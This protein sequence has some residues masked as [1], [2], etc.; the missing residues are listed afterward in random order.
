MATLVR[1]GFALNSGEWLTLKVTF[2]QDEFERA[3]KQA[4]LKSQFTMAAGQ[5]G[6]AREG[7][8]KFQKQLMGILAEIA[9][10]SFLFAILDF[11]R[12]L[13]GKWEVFRYD[14]VRTDGFKSSKNEYDIR[15]RKIDNS[16]EYYEVESRSSITYDR[17]FKVGLENFDIIGPYSSTAKSGEH[18][19]YIYLRPLYRYLDFKESPYQPLEF[20][21]LMSNGRIELYLV[22]GC[23]SEDMESKGYDKSMQQSGTK[24]RAVKISDALDIIKFSEEIIKIF[25]AL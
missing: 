16:N 21:K 9:C 1:T 25:K 3:C 20:E 15:V 14:D 6:K 13:K 10:Q 18:A 12:N 11:N 23:T 7:A 22:A 19:N 24:Y 8:T 5:D 4:E 2:N 17:D